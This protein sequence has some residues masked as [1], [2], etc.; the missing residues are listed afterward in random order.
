MPQ[1]FRLL[2]FDHSGCVVSSLK[3]TLAF[4]VDAMGGKLVR[5]TTSRGDTLGNI[6]GAYGAEADIAIVE[7]AGQRIE[8]LEYRG[9]TPP[10]VAPHRPYDIGALH[11]AFRVDDIEAAVKHVAGHGYRPQG[12]PQLT[13]ANTVNVYV[14]GPDG[15]TIEFMQPVET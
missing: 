6:T 12:R 7:I 14:V 3:D 11:V 5:S 15:A 8:F 2:N 10:G 9:V 4:W 13:A 1:G